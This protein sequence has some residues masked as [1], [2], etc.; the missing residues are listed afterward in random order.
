M[1]AFERNTGRAH[2]H[3]LEIR[4]PNNE[5]RGTGSVPLTDDGGTYSYWSG[6]VTVGTPGSTFNGEQPFLLVRPSKV[7]TWCIVNFDTGSSD[8]ILFDHSCTSCQGHKLYDSSKSSTAGF[9]GDPVTIKYGDSN[10]E[11]S[12]SVD[13]YS[14]TVNL[15]GYKVSGIFTVC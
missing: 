1:D 3:S 13:Q 11:T 7:I 12:V 15:G 10:G 14:D 6:P 2:P 8:L 9:I 5:R 4:H